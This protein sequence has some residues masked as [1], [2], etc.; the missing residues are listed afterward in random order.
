M[1]IYIT[2]H[3]PEE[4]D[5]NSIPVMPPLE[6]SERPNNSANLHHAPYLGL[7]LNITVIPCYFYF[8]I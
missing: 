4:M 8:D 1:Y 6:A 3:S 5:G 7:Y 2:D